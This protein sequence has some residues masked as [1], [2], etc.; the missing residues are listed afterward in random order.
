MSQV[1]VSDLQISQE[2]D[3]EAL[4]AVLGG[5]RRGGYKGGRKYYRKIKFLYEEKYQEH[6]RFKRHNP[7]YDYH[8]SPRHYDHFHCHW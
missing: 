6:Y 5:M 1:I 2:L 3:H 7:C 4:N 8:Y